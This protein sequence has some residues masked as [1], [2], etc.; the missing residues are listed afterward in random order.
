[1]STL[2]EQ[3][4]DALSRVSEL[5]AATKE[6]DLTSDELT[7]ANNL[8]EQVTSLREQVKRADDAQA[9][10]GAISSTEVEPAAKTQAA[11]IGGAFVNSAEYKSFR[12]AHPSGFGQGT[13]V[14]IDRVKV[15]DLTTLGRKAA[16]DEGATLQAGLAF[17]QPTRLP[18]ID[19][20][21][22]PPLDFLDFISRG[23][24][25]TNSFEY[26][27]VV[28]VSRNAG[29]V[30][31]EILP[32]DDTLKPLS[33]FSTN[34]A[35]A[36]VYT[37]ADGYAV[38]NMMLADAQALATYLNNQLGYNIQKVVQDKLI[39][40][41]GTNG[42]PTGLMNTTGVQQQD[43]AGDI[44]TTVRKAIT[45]LNN[46][47]APITAIAVSP[48]DNET[49]D[50]MMDANQRYYGGGPFQSGPQTLWGQPRVVCQSLPDGVA[51]VGNLKTITLLDREGLNVQAF[52]QH[53]DWARRNLVYVRA[54]LRAGQAI[55]KPSEIVVCDT[56]K[57]GNGGGGGTE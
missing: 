39:N 26:L 22:P 51:L 8:P 12:D 28:S 14:Q 29:I 37:Y 20:T 56:S 16:G 5:Q 24:M 53:A 7:E 55:F 47:G 49:L 11:G 19:Q 48:A 36:K 32:G 44:P 50:L 33:D 2:R 45:R 25:G 40:G 3:L 10:I 23:T 54:E 15:G 27:Q 30:P 18:M 38:T 41:A 35:D 4:N 21:Y 6:R 31:D 34:L 1:M 9:N 57:S 42:E 46:I 43:N 13:P 17:P 52:N